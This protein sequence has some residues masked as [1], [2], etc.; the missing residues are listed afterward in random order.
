MQWTF[1]RG[2]LSETAARFV[3]L[4]GSVQNSRARAIGTWDIAD[5]AAHVLLVARL[6]SL[7]T[8]G[9]EPDEDLVPVVAEAANVDFTTVSNM[10]QHG[11]A[12]IDMNDVQV[13][14][15]RIEEQLQRLLDDSNQL[16][17]SDTITW[18]G[19]LPL[20]R[21]AVLAHMV[22][23]LLLH[24][25]DIARAEGRTFGLPATAA[26]QYFELFLV[27]VIRHGYDSG[28]LPDLGEADS[29]PP[30]S[31]ELRLRGSR[32]LAFAYDHGRVRIKPVGPVDVHISAD[33][34]AMLL[35]MYN[36]VKPLGPAIRGQ[37]VPWGRRPWKL[38]RLMEVMQLP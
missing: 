34:G 20:S 6:N 7:F 22:S 23:E 1:V 4:L 9:G 18:L 14:A 16:R 29:G 2:A 15:R 26:R 32:P 31:W 17:G 12:I 8:I 33:P 3:D 13:L 19:G 5:T 30:V 10:N 36:R 21:S 11:R 35:M 27:Q 25:F 24:G 37:V 28:F 38:K